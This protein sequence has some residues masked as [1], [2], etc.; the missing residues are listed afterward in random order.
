MK[1][2]KKF[3]AYLLK[4]SFEEYCNE[5]YKQVQTMD[6][7]LMRLFAHLPA[8]E[9]K[10]LAKV[11][12]QKFLTDFKQGIALEQAEKALKL[13]ETDTMPGIPK[14]AIHPSDL[15]LIYAA[16][17]LTL[18]KYLLKYTS[19]CKEIVAIIKELEEYYMTI[20]NNAV[21]L[22]FKIQKDVEAALEKKNKQLEEAQSIAHIGSW[23]WDIRNDTIIWSD[24]LYRIYGMQP[25]E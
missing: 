5:Y 16:Q 6:I 23:E 25:Q 21:Q 7:P 13:W 17:K 10:E 9:L 14:A 8:N 4:E 11:G 12:V 19:N 24:E 3:A 18:N 15:V 22:L 2:L 20:Q 1:A